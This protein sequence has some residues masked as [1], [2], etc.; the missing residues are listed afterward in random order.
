MLNLSRDLVYYT[1]T[2]ITTTSTTTTTTIGLQQG[3]VS[4]LQ[5]FLRRFKRAEESFKNTKH[6]FGRDGRSEK[7]EVAYLYYRTTLARK[8]STMNNKS[9]TKTCEI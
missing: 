3:L 8:K 1:T 9:H 4:S 7:S 6:I 5:S 2:T